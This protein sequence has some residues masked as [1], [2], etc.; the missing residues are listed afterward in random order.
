MRGGG[1]RD[2]ASGRYGCFLGMAEEVIGAVKERRESDSKPQE[3]SNL[4]I[5][6]DWR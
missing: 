2:A 6:Q 4:M 5:E 3:E 1:E